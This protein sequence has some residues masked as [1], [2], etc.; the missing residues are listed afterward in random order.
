[1]SLLNIFKKTATKKVP[2]QR[3]IPPSIQSGFNTQMQSTVQQP[4]KTEFPEVT[5]EELP[6]YTEWVNTTASDLVIRLLADTEVDGSLYTYPGL[7]SYLAPTGRYMF[8]TAFFAHKH[9]YT[10]LST[11]GF[12]LDTSHCTDAAQVRMYI[13]DNVVLL[14]K[15]EPV[16]LPLGD[17]ALGSNVPNPLH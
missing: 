2:T 3:S 16:R 9:E 12:I 13:C 6:E 17:Y 10:D 8:P 5:W 15:R 1:M 11:P 4:K 7:I 14:P